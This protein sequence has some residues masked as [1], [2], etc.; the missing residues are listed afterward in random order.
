[1]VLPCV[2]TALAVMCFSNS[3]LGQS[4]DAGNTPYSVQ[5]VL[6]SAVRVEMGALHRGVLD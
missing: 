6:T 3:P 1:M 5:F 2:F 4:V